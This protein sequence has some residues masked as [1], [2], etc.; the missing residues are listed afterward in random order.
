MPVLAETIEKEVVVD[1]NS[2]GLKFRSRGRQWSHQSF[3]CMCGKCAEVPA[4]VVAPVPEASGDDKK[5]KKTDAKGGKMSRTSSSMDL[6][7]ATTE[8]PVNAPVKCAHCPFIFHL[9]CCNGPPPPPAPV[10]VEPKGS[11]KRPPPPPA[12]LTRPAGMF[13]CPHHRCCVCN[14]STASAG[15]LLFR[16][17]GCLTAYCEDCLPQDEI[18]SVGRCKPLEKLG[19]DSKQSYFIRCPYCCQL[20]GFKPGGILNDNEEANKQAKKKEDEE[21]RNLSRGQ[22]RTSLNGSRSMASLASMGERG[23]A[24]DDEVVGENEVLEGAEEAE[25]PLAAEQD[26]A[27]DAIVPLKTQLMRLHWTEV[28]DPIPEP[29]PSPKKRKS[30]SKKKGKKGAKAAKGGSSTSSSGRKASAAVESGSESEEED[31]ES[32]IEEPVDSLTEAAVVW[33]EWSRP[34]GANKTKKARTEGTTEVPEE[35]PAAEGV[36]L[37]LDHPLWTALRQVRI[38]SGLL[39]EGEAG[40][41][42][43]EQRDGDIQLFS[44]V[45]SK[46][47]AGEYC[48]V[49]LA[50]LPSWNLVVVAAVL[51]AFRV[52]Y[53]APLYFIP[54]LRA[55]P[56]HRS[57]GGRPALRDRVQHA[58]E[59]PREALQGQRKSQA[60]RAARALQHLSRPRVRP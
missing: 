23:D 47:E 1:E 20:D 19:Y 38:A 46:I 29:E 54:S 53:R 27:E 24:S 28:V 3:C 7:A 13:I 31:S 26:S 4:P 51:F 48:R 45:L 43:S 14:R 16:C 34:G 40:L 58:Q 15:G 11:K 17:N 9:E 22:S 36:L 37:L 8:V 49:T 57:C 44:H 35:C 59:G 25:E 50:N 2:D 56:V 32:E 18:D 10:V 39:S 5:G 52:A 12:P 21:S 6:P 55:V 60:R 33:R 42:A 41:S 30:K